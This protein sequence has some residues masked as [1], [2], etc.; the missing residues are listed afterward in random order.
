MNLN[1]IKLFCVRLDVFEVLHLGEERF[2]EI[3]FDIFDLFRSFDFQVVLLFMKGRD[4]VQEFAEL[5]FMV[6]IFYFGFH[7]EGLALL[8]GVFEEILILS[9]KK[10][11]VI[12]SVF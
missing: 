7:K 1:L 3:S 2:L 9:F 11:D 5:K 12:L 4:F 10:L 8:R 6:G